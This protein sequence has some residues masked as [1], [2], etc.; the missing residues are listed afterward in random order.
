MRVL[1][2]SG[3][4]RWACKAWASATGNACSHAQS[5]A[6]PHTSVDVGRRLETWRSLS[7]LA[8]SLSAAV[9]EIV[10]ETTKAVE[11]RPR[12][13]ATAE[14]TATV[15]TAAAV[16]T[17]ATAEAASTTETA[18]VVGEAVADV[19]PTRHRQLIRPQPSD[20]SVFETV[21]APNVPSA[22]IVAPSPPVAVSLLS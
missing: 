8:V 18:A 13:H 2:G 15:E 4:D 9:P 14:I 20:E 17:I 10:I 12:H 19:R 22:P 11:Q 21:S 6:L 7:L 16:E 5:G 3:G 1:G